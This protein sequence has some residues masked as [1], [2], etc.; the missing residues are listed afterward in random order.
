MLRVN[1]N[2]HVM[3]AYFAHKSA[4]LHAFYARVGAAI[5]VA[6]TVYYTIITTHLYS[7]VGRVVHKPH[8]GHFPFLLVHFPVRYST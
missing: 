8:A 4:I 1:F 6:S 3:R 5:P 2:L 7:K